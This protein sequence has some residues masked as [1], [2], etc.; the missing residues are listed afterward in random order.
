[1]ISHRIISKSQTE[2]LSLLRYYHDTVLA[3]DFSF[4]ACGIMLDEIKLFWLERLESLDFELGKLTETNTDCF[5]LSGAIYLNVAEYEHYY[6]RTLGNYHFLQDPLMKMDPFIRLPEN[7]VNVGAT[8]QYYR[9]VFNDT[10]EVLTKYRDSFCILP[11]RELSITDERKH[12]DLLK[13]GFLGV[14]SSAFNTDVESEQEFC[15][16]YPTFEAL[17]Q[18]MVE[19]VRPLFV[20]STEGAGP[21]DSLRSKMEAYASIELNATSLF[22]AKTE[23]QRFLIA[24]FSWI[25][26][27]LDILAICLVLRMNPYIRFNLTF[28]YLLM[29]MH[30]FQRDETMRRIIGNA[31]IFFILRRVVSPD[32]FQRFTFEEYDQI[33]KDKD[34]LA[35]ISRALEDKGI[36]LFQLA[37]QAESV[38]S[39]EFAS[40]IET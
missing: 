31:I 30:S 17:E 5:L 28:H 2:Y 34:L 3:S 38:I 6:F 9:R 8:L 26:Q 24:A 14:L 4:R 40:A 35:R 32:E 16:V 29:L 39:E 1:M 33:L 11:I 21:S 22:K 20:F 10:L 18:G 12:Q 36:D 37:S 13:E 23:P 7:Q 19:S 15:R 25:A 27:I